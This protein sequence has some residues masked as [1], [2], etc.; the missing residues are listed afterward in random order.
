[1]D[2]VPTLHHTHFYGSRTLLIGRYLLDGDH[3][4]T[5]QDYY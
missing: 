3:Y 1:M 5:Y 4:D 2:M